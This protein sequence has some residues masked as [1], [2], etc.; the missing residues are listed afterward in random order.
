MLKA[1]ALDSPRKRKA[2]KLTKRLKDAARGYN[3]KKWQLTHARRFKLANDVKDWSPTRGVQPSF[4]D[5][6]H[7]LTPLHP[8]VSCVLSA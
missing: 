5:I 4:F 8:K 1:E 6:T 2:A 7:N 3:T